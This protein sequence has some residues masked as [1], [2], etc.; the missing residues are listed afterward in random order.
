MKTIVKQVIK[1]NSLSFRAS[2]VFVCSKFNENADVNQQRS[3]TGFFYR[4][5]K[6]LFFITNWHVVSG[7]HP[8]TDNLTNGF[9]PTE[10]KI[11]VRDKNT[12]SKAYT[13]DYELYEEGKADW[14]I[15]PKYGTQVDVVALKL[16][17]NYDDS[18]VEIKTINEIVFDK[19]E[20]EVAD[21]IFILGYP[22]GLDSGLYFPL[23]KKGSIASE[24][25][26]DY[27][28]LPRVVI[29]CATREGMSGAP[30]IIK[31]TGIHDY[32]LNQPS[33]DWTIGTIQDFLGIYSGRIDVTDV[34]SA[35]L[36]IVWK[37]SVIEEIIEGNQKDTLII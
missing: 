32:N 33:N 15:H 5:N 6:D 25:G 7:K 23:W 35:H 24:P 11:A 29:D 36:G 19:L 13:I 3:A 16:T 12:P 28:G 26:F 30:V 9:I 27:K 18:D 37:K 1:P 8:D 31:R 4:H 2:K 21:E 14:F 10:L 22:R 20:P 17:S 34:L